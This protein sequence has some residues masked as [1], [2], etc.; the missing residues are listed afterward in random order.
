MVLEPAIDMVEL[1]PLKRMLRAPPETKIFPP[2]LIKLR[3]IPVPMFKRPMLFNSKTFP[4][5]PEITV[6]LFNTTP[7]VTV[8]ATTRKAKLLVAPV[9]LKLPVMFWV[10]EPLNITARLLCVNVPFCVK[11]PPICKSPP[12]TVDKVKPDVPKLATVMLLLHRR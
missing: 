12:A 11:L 8:D 3:L 10:V 9:A 6:L 7:F 2:L 1:P 4:L 5:D